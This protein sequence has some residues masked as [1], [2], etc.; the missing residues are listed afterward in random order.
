MVYYYQDILSFCHFIKKQN[1]ANLIYF[2]YSPRLKIKN[3]IKI[4]IDFSKFV[5]LINFTSLIKLLYII[6]LS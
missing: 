4:N 5:K 6:H 3:K 1:K 2:Y